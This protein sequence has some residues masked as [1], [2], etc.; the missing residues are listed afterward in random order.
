[1]DVEST[2]YVRFARRL[3]LSDEAI[4]T[5]LNAK[6]RDH[7]RTP[8]PWTAAPDGG[9]G[10]A[11]PWLPLHPDHATFAADK[12][13]ADPHSVFHHYRRLVALRRELP[14]VALGE[15]RLLA[16]DH[17]RLWAFERRLG[18]GA[19]LVVANFSD[20]DLVLAEAGVE[21]PEGAELLLANLRPEDGL[22]DRATLRG[23]EARVVR[24]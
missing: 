1:M 5:P 20:A 10:S 9:F 17:E 15:F 13:R 18:E 14:V 12:Q 2:N 6:S 21:I 22:G 19:L 8:V 11:D 7:A 24:L 16:P 4:L 23:W 3:G